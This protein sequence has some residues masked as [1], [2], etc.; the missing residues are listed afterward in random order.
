MTLRGSQ[1][2]STNSKNSMFKIKDPKDEE[3]LCS[4]CA[5]PIPN[6]TPKFFE[7]IPINPA[8]TKCGDET[9]SKTAD[10]NTETENRIHTCCLPSILSSSLVPYITS[11]MVSHWIPITSKCFQSP[12]SVTTM[13]AH[14]SKL[15]SPGSSFISMEEVMKELEKMFDRCLE[16]WKL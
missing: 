14:C 11:S 7:G 13:V 16:K 5:N 3:T 10:Q 9:E 1:A 2:A 15:P 6:Y 4:I 12:G 8:C